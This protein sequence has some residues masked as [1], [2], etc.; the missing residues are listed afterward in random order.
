[1][2]GTVTALLVSHDGTRWL[3]TVLRELA[4]Q[5]RRPDHVVALDTGSTDTSR[6]LLNAAEVVDEV[7]DLGPASYPEAV[8]RGLAHIADRGW[9]SEWVWLLH[10]DAAPAADALARLLEAA[11]A[12]PGADVLGPK[13]REWPSL[14]RL[15]EIGVTVTGT[16]SRETGLERGEYDQGQHD[17]PARVLAVNTAGMLVRRATLERLGLDPRL[18]LVHTDLDFGWRAARAGAEVRTVPDA[19]VFHAEAT[20]NGRRTPVRSV[21]GRQ[22]RL[23][24]AALYL[25][26]VN[27]AA[28]ALPLVSLRLLL[29]TV[30]RALGYL[31]V[32]SPAQAGGEL[33]G[34]AEVYLRPWRVLAG[35]RARRASAT[36]SSRSVRPLLASAWT[37]YRHGIDEL[38]ET[39]AAVV[40]EVGSRSAQRRQGQQDSSLLR[41]LALSPGTAV[42]AV[43]VLAAV[44]AARGALG[45]GPLHGAALLPAPDGVGHWWDTYLSGRHDLGVGSTTTAPAYLLPLALA[46]TVLLGATGLLV[47]LLV[48]GAV[49]LAAAGAYRALRRLAADRPAAAWGAATYGLLVAT[50]GAWAQGRLGTLVAGVLLPWLVVSAAGLLGATPEAAE[51]RRRSAWRTAVWLALVLAFA[52]V[53]VLPALVVTVVAA[54][55]VVRGRLGRA[56]LLPLPVAAVLLA[57]WSLLV[58]SDRGPGALLLEAG[59]PAPALVG[60]VGPLDL[61]AGRAG[62]VGAAPVWVGLVLVVVGVLALLRRTS[63]PRVLAAWLTALVAWVPAAALSGASV[64]LPASP[65]PVAVWVGALLVLAGGALVVA[66]VLAVDGLTDELGGVAFGVRQLTGALTALAAVVATAGALVWW[67]GHGPDLLGRDDPVDVP[68]YML[69]AGQDDPAAGTLVVTGSPADGVRVRLLR[70]D[71][72]R[73]GDDAVA[74]AVADQR[75]LLDTVATLLSAPTPTTVADLAAQGVRFLHAP[76]PVDPAVQAQLDGVPGLEVSSAPVGERAWRL[77]PTASWTR[78]DLGVAAVLRPLLLAVQ[79][80]VLATVLVLA[81]PSRP[82]RRG[83]S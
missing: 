75:S 1:M 77:E 7:V 58:W 2:T 30:L 72:E 24:A 25:V 10:D 68:V 13:L 67:V 51:R 53:L 23:R 12:N 48:L 40:A 73:L 54:V 4:A 21:A 16:G 14:R 57:P 5:S 22:R 78:P 6:D 46:A 42:V 65:T 62:D 69:Q 11:E 28:A 38:A 43:L 81:A 41:R 64:E 32:R 9:D 56:A 29:G 71:V 82:N 34:L 31:L 47:S 17:R 55:L 70:G 15:L 50:G 39:A 76:A 83:R 52:P 26:L 79:A 35:R 74:P 44:V 37:P 8:R 20:G 19:V 80:L 45:G 60:P 66:A 27:C 36:V 63:R 18:P 59:L 3:P 33:A 61:L 49:P